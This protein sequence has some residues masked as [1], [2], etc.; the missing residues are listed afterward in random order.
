LGR[1]KIII[2]IVQAGIIGDISFLQTFPQVFTFSPLDSPGKV[3][4]QVVEYL[5]QQQLSKERQ[6]AIGALV[7]IGLGLLLLSGL[8]KE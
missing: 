8:S 3:E 4:A 7:A 2:P 5:R 6:Q 1:N